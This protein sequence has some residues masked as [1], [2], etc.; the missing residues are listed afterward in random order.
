MT[1]SSIQNIITDLSEKLKKRRGLIIPADFS[2]NYKLALDMLNQVSVHSQSRQFPTDLMKAKA[3]NE[4]V[5]E[6][7]YRKDIFEP[8]TRPYW[9]RALGAIN[10]I[11]AE[12]NYSITWNDPV[13]QQYF[14]QQFP[15]HGSLLT[16]FKTLVTPYKI[17]DPNAVLMVD[18]G[19]IPVM[20]DEDTGEL[21]VD[22]SKELSPVCKIY[23]ADKVLY[24]DRDEYVFVLGEDNSL[25]TGRAD[26]QERTGLV[27]YLM[28]TT[29]LFRIY[30]Y[31]KKSDYEFK[32]TELYEHN[33][34]YLPARRLGGKQISQSQDDDIIYESY[35]MPAIPNLNKALK[36][37]STLDISIN[38]MAYPIRSYY[39]MPCT[40]PGCNG[41][42][43]LTKVYDP[44]R[45]DSM[46]D[47]PTA[48]ELSTCNICN[49]RGTVMGFSPTRDY[50]H[51]PRTGSSGENP[52]PFPGF[53]YISPDPTIL[54]FNQQKIT[55]DI[56]RA[57][58][59]LN[60]DVSLNSA[61]GAG[62]QG[63]NKTATQS[64]IDRE[65]LFSFLL[66][67]S[68]ELFSLLRFSI[69]TILQ[70]R[71]PNSGKAPVTIC[72]PVTFEIRSLDEITAE[73]QNAQTNN[74]PDAVIR[75]LLKEYVVLR[76][77]T[78]KNLDVILKAA[79]YCDALITKSDNNIALLKGQNLISP[80]DAVLHVH[81]FYFLEQKLMED[82]NYFSKKLPDIKND[83][84]AM[85]K[86]KVAELQAP[87]PPKG[88]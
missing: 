21:V 36:L 14:T 88:A 42:K 28:T 61:T 18:V 47:L 66:I 68:E 76:F 32:V 16:Y 51:T 6:L 59:F 50:V 39:E 78:A 23:A 7:Q 33:L 53:A 71:Y 5:Q 62:A 52:I 67:I 11:W 24:F 35:F 54:Q 31:G 43:V 58:M 30:Q 83:M 72:P 69:N 77:S 38:K 20:E 82:E 34:G 45:T 10:R 19:E 1:P 79:F 48:A 60:I 29:T 70:L 25:V 17:N 40:N 37:D 73:I 27:F 4:T 57:F 8:I 84:V 49:G 26:K 41:G 2:S 3:P 63:A 65:E 85:A 55:E 13:V 44:S 75:E 56:E 22:Q 81:I 46:G 80:P 15:V 12:Q 74:A 64:K 9:D 86:E 87:Q